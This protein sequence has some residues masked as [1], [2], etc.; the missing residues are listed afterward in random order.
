MAPLYE[1]GKGPFAVEGISGACIM[2]PRRAFETVHGFSE[3]YFMYY[4][5]MDYCL[6]VRKAGHRNYYAPAAEIVHHGGKSSAS[7]QSAFSSVM[8]AESGR[9]FFRKEQGAFR[10]GV[11]R[12]TMAAKALLRLCVLPALYILTWPAGRRSSVAAACRKWISVFRW[13][14]GAEKWAASYQQP[15]P[16]V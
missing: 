10:A 7:A 5:D 3:D 12:L 9:R 15:P 14:F 13:A 1:K 4:E 11:F 16:D 6:K 2:T 8:M